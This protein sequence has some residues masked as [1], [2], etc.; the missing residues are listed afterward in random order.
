MEKLDRARTTL[1]VSADRGG[2]LAAATGRVA[3]VVV[4]RSVECF[5]KAGVEPLKKQTLN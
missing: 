5:R 3:V 1:A 4:T 2:K